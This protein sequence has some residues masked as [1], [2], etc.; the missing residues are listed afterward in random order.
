MASHHSALNHKKPM[1]SIDPPTEKIFIYLS[2]ILHHKMA[3]VNPAQIAYIVYWHD[4]AS[5]ESEGSCIKTGT[6]KDALDGEYDWRLTER[7][8]WLSMSDP[9]IVIFDGTSLDDFMQGHTQRYIER[10]SKGPCRTPTENE[11]KA[12]YRQ[13]SPG[14][15]DLSPEVVQSRVLPM[16]TAPTAQI[17]R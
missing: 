2:D 4:V 6:L 17:Y 10:F 8:S 14:F 16:F 9:R 12:L 15:R 1:Y 3:Q 5:R 13:L 7:P 11:L